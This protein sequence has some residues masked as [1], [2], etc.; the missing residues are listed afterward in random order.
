MFRGRKIGSGDHCSILIFLL[1]LSVLFT[2]G[3]PAFAGGP[4]HGARAAGMGTAFVGL[5]DDPSAILFNP[6]GLTQLKGTQL[7]GGVTAVHPSTTYSNT[8]GASESTKSQTFF[9]PHL[10]FTTDS[11]GSNLVLGLG[12]YSPFGIGGRKW[13][14]TG[15]TRYQSVESSIATLSLNPTIAWRVS[16]SISLAAGIDYLRAAMKMKR[17]LDQSLFGAGDAI[18]EVEADGDGWGYNLGAMF[19]AGDRLKIGA[20]YR[21]AV[22]VEYRGD[23][24]IEKIAPALQPPFSGPSYKTAIETQ[25]RFPEIWSLGA[26]YRFSP[27]LV[28]A[29]DAELVRWSSFKTMA[30]HIDQQVPP[31]LVD[32]SASLDWKDSWQFKIGAEYAASDTLALRAGYAYIN[33]PVP[34]Q[35]LEPGNPDADQHN[36]SVGI[37]YTAAPYRV[38]GFYSVSLYRDRSP[39]NGMLRGTYENI[40][41]YLGV[42]V[43]RAF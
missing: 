28:V 4:V 36:I 2:A 12:L 37:G 23:M 11:A 30:L 20:A 8:S 34:D 1:L 5:S 14:E 25:N 31:V 35:S 43:G 9:P 7:Y 39:Q 29:A 10:Y 6:A 38:D 41:H 13:D 22:K 33:T 19:R 3:P 24:T 21:S 32:S 15:L 40:A 27:K 42:S 26:A 16:D 18:S 17:M